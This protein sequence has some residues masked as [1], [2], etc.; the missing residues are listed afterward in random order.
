V[1]GS[2]YDDYWN[3]YVIAFFKEVV[4][5]DLDDICMIPE[6][7]VGNNEQLLSEGVNLTLMAV[8]I[9][10]CAER[11]SLTLVDADGSLLP[12]V[13]WNLARLTTPAT[14]PVFLTPSSVYMVNWL[15]SELRIV[16]Q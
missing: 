12:R 5:E 16:E 15:P 7:V 9:G 10:G 8:R 4:E 1:L 2:L 14:L 13:S 6:S 11:L 3:G